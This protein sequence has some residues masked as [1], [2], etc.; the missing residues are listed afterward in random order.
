MNIER[1]V[2]KSWQITWH[3][4]RLWVLALAMFV[5]Y[6]PAGLL[7][8]GLGWA[9]AA[10]TLS[11]SS[12]PV[13][14]HQPA[15]SRVFLSVPRPAWFLILLVGIVIMVLTSLASWILQAA[16]MRAVDRR[17]AGQ[18]LSLLQVL[19]LGRQRFL[20]IVKVS[21]TLGALMV[22]ISFTPLLIM[23]LAPDSAP[24]LAIMQLAQGILAP[25]EMGLSLA[26][27]IILMSIS[28][29]DLRPRAAMLRSWQVFQRGW[30][31]FLLVIVISIL[32]MLALTFLLLPLFVVLPFVLM[33]DWGWMVALL[34]C[35]MLSPL[36]LLVLLFTAV[37]SLVLYTVVYRE[38]SEAG[39][40]WVS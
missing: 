27:L 14:E 23:F 33:A 32:A 15:W 35:G 4:W 26:L 24:G 6:L 5:T 9:T 38:A 40:N 20:S 12:S 16:S 19:S 34:C 28:L 37:F 30:W 31:G 22:L 11:V 39:Q 3:E 2:K 10:I 8:L 7:S 36:G 13:F 18:S 1:I 29:E 21:L 17:V 25:L